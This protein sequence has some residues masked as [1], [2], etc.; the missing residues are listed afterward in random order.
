MLCTGLLNTDMPL[1]RYRNGDRGIVARKASTCA[2]GR[3]LPELKEI[4][5]RISDLIITPDG[6]RLSPA[7][8]EIIYDEEHPIAEAQLVQHALDH[9]TLRYVPLSG[10]DAQAER[11]LRR[12][13]VKILGEVRVDLQAMDRIPRGPNGK[14]RAVVSELSLQQ[15]RDALSNTSR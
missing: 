11:N 1:I 3:P 15:K 6:R 9:V 13:V 4:E 10:F 2:C 14:M 12:S 5:G 8:V 7:Y